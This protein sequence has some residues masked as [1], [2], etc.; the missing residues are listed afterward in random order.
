MKRNYGKSLMMWI[1]ALLSEGAIMIATLNLAASDY[2]GMAI[3]AFLTNIF[4]VWFLVH[5]FPWR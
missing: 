2:R 1:A 3:A 4:V 5:E